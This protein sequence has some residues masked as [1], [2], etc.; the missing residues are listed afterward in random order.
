MIIVH[1]Q[2]TVYEGRLVSIYPQTEIFC[3]ED[4]ELLTKN[5]L[6]FVTL[7]D[8]FG[9]TINIKIDKLSQIE[10]VD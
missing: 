9:A 2:G 7:E 6:Y 1:T 8:A 5:T 4:R 10:V 3:T